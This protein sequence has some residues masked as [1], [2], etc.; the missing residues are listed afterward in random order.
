MHSDYMGGAIPLRR[1]F[2]FPGHLLSLEGAVK[3]FGETVLIL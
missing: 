2:R 3:F 1:G